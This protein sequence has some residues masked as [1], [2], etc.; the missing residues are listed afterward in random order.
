MKL[1]LWITFLLNIHVLCINIFFCYFKKNIKN[2]KKHK[3]FFYRKR[4]YIIIYIY[5]KKGIYYVLDKEKYFK[6]IMKM[7]II[8][9]R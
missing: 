2:I 3:N 1:L 5:K 7:D 4:L 6:I 9:H 8:I